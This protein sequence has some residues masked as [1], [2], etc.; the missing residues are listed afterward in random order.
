[1]QRQTTN[2]RSRRERSLSGALVTVEPVTRVFEA[3]ASTSAVELLVLAFNALNVEQQEAALQQIHEIRLQRLAGE[4]SE[5]ARYLR[6]LRRISEHVGEELS[7]EKYIGAYRELTAAGEELVEFNQLRRYFGSWRRA[8]EALSLSE[9]NTPFK[10]EARFRARMVGKP[11]RYREETLRDSL[12]QCV[13]ALGR[14]PLVIDFELWRQKEI[15]LARAQGR[16]LFIPS[17]SPY[18]SR[19]GSWEKALLHFG[20]PEE[21]VKGRLEPSAEQNVARL[22]AMSG[23]KRS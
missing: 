22:A 13:Q 11:G 19:Y 23:P 6:S 3:Q 7:P 14:L 5:T 15:E 16:E 17:D 2:R 9:S 18:R 12:E 10:I 21:E 1:M 4:E 20:Y 8:K